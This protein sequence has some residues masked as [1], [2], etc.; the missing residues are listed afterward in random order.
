MSLMFP[1]TEF[2]PSPVGPRTYA[3]QF[4]LEVRCTECARIDL[5]QLEMLDE[6][7]DSAS[8]DDL[9]TSGAVDRLDW[10]CPRCSCESFTVL[11]TA[12]VRHPL[13]K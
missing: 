10:S 8:E 1:P 7:D 5:V 6:I 2:R 4:R 12:H 3:R 11:R 9:L 13:D